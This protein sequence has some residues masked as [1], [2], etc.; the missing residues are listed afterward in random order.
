MLPARD[1]KKE[2][3]E[4]EEEEENKLSL[5][6]TDGEEE[7]LHWFLSGKLRRLIYVEIARMQKIRLFSKGRA[8]RKLHACIKCSDTTTHALLIR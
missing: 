1:E 6:Y 3:E 7:L 5:I 8:K 2:E 4:E